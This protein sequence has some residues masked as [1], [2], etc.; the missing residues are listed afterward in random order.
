MTKQVLKGTNRVGINLST[1]CIIVEG[2]LSV[3]R[4]EKRKIHIMKETRS[5]HTSV[6]Y[7]S[8]C[9]FF[10]HDFE[11]YTKGNE[12]SFYPERK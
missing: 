11:H 2:N 10:R 9:P 1:A 7:N 4:G 8:Q 12:S 5:W 6:S 3:L